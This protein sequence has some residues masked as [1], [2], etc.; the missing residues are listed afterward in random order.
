MDQGIIQNLK[1]HYRKRLLRR[2]I[3]AIDSG[4]EFNFNL[5][6]AVFILDK[7]WN[8]VKTTTIG[9]CFRKAGFTFDDQ[10]CFEDGLAVKFIGFQAEVQIED[11]EDA[12]LQRFWLTIQG[13]DELKV[14]CEL[15][16]FLAA[17]DQ[18]ETSGALTIQEI[19]QACSS[20]NTDKADSDNENEASEIEERA[21]IT[22]PAA[23]QAYIQL[24]QYFEENDLDSTL[25]P[26]FDRMEDELTKDQLAKMKQPTLHNFFP[27]R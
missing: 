4:S 10:V 3:A 23:R 8:D 20:S 25:F 2:R 5:L 16:D 19:A 13:H 18:V 22:G 6:D 1:V 14:D 9:N 7:A 11:A 24:R 21:P 12:D 17:D 15:T 26:A 27:S